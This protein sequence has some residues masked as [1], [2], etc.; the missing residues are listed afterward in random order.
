MKLLFDQYQRYKNA[1]LLI[2]NFRKNGEKFRILEVGAN[3]H[4][5]LEHFLPEDDIL[6]LD[7]KLSE[8][9]LKDEHYILGDATDME[10]EDNS[11]DII[12]ALDVYEHVLPERRINFLREVSRVAKVGFVI[13]APF[14]DEMGAVHRAEERMSEAYRVLYGIPHPW[15]REHL[16]NG[17]PKL[18]ETEQILDELGVPYKEISHGALDVWERMMYMQ[19][20]ADYDSRLLSYFKTISEYY[21]EAMFPEDYAE[22]SYRKFIIGDKQNRGLPTEGKQTKRDEKFEFL[23]RIYL[24]LLENIKL[25]KSLE[26]ESGIQAEMR[27]EI[28]ANKNQRRTELYF[29]EGNGFNGIL[30]KE[31]VIQGNK[32]NIRWNIPLER[33]IFAFRFDPVNESALLKIH[34]IFV[35]DGNEY[36]KELSADDLDGCMNGMIHLYKNYYLADCED[37]QI[38]IWNDRNIKLIE[39][40]MDVYWMETNTALCMHEIREDAEDYYDTHEAVKKDLREQCNILRI[41]KARIENEK[42]LEEGKA[43]QYRQL[44]EATVNSVC[45]RITSPARWVGDVFSQRLISRAIQCVKDNGLS[46]TINLYKTGGYDKGN[47]RVEPL[48]KSDVKDNEYHGK[49]I[50]FFKI[51]KE[52]T[53]RQKNY[54]FSKNTKFSILVPLYNTDERFLREMIESVQYQTYENWELCL[55]DGSDEDHHEVGEICKEYAEEDSRILYKKLERNEGISGNTNACIDMASGDYISLFDHDDILHPCALFETMLAITEKNADYVYTDEATFE[56]KNI[57]RIITRHCKPDFAI[58]NLR[59]NNYICHFSSFKKELLD[60]AGRFRSDYDG[61]QDHDLILRLTEVAEH[62]YHIPKILYYWRS[63][64][65]SVAQDINAKTYAINAAKRAVESHLQRAGLEAELLSTRAF[66]T[67]FQINY[68]II[69]H[70]R[71]SIIIPNKDHVEDLSRCLISI[72]TKSSYDNYEIIVVENNSEKPETM[73]YYKMIEGVDKVQIIKYTGAFNYSKINNFGRQ[74]ATGEYLLLLN[75]DTEVIST[76][77]MEQLLMYA[78]RDDVGA[79]GAKLYF[80]DGT[81]QHAGIVLGLGADRTAG[82]THYGI[83]KE[84]LGYMGRLCYTQNVSAV[85]AACLMVSAKKFDEVHGITEELAVAL[86]DVDFCLKLRRKGYLNIFNPFAELYHY[87]SKSRGLDSSSTGK[88]KAR[89]EREVA[90]FKETWKEELEAGDPYYNPNF[91]LDRSDYF[92]VGDAGDE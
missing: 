22:I 30:K 60:K 36:K 82:H 70:P 72:M 38:Y 73:A 29:D 28:Q 78:Q 90:L 69:G 27:A 54:N 39:V 1:Q 2:D 37:P 10:F 65:K 83:E 31:K 63:H 87:E 56:G 85:T 42:S 67:I 86:N 14:A 9:K 81:I 15:L 79:V 6:Y 46:Y 77:W 74:H 84:N 59:A 52:E 53:E 34:R 25:N 12:V 47:V 43:E 45:W 51:K 61:S 8:E 21:N 16:E 44:Y 20:M 91:S 89:Y 19:I 88:K 80:P 5:N 24:S 32:V 76:D 3:E 66:P 64:A 58:D 49:I 11:F 33:K 71:I 7:I 18:K 23:G 50:D 55:A 57:S 48:V 13:C 17:L 68:K 35:T 26:L 41:E 75:N 92:Y 62:V 40:D 4:K